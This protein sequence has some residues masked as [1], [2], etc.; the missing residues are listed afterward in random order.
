MILLFIQ[1]QQLRYAEVCQHGAGMA[2][3]K[4]ENPTSTTE[5]HYIIRIILLILILCY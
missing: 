2:G 5:E 3:E 4:N 1:L